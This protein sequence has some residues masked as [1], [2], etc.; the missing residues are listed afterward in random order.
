MAA[1][2]CRTPSANEK[3]DP[4]EHEHVEPNSQRTPNAKAEAA[5]FHSRKASLSLLL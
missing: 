3:D 4:S 2:N 1:E 5:Q